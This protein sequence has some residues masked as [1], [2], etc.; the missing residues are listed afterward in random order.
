MSY[1]TPVTDRTLLDVVNQTSKG[2]FNAAD[3]ARVYNNAQLVNY[4]VVLYSGE[5]IVFHELTAP[6]R[7]TIP[8]GTADFNLFLTNIENIRAEMVASI[9]T[10]IAIKTDWESGINVPSPKYTHANQWESTLDAVWEFLDGNAIP[11]CTSLVS[12]RTILAGN[13]DLYIDCL[14]LQN[15]NL[16]IQGTGQLIIL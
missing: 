2:F 11:V 4:L 10:L 1:I 3:W 6:T 13:Y 5:D 14:D 9:P 12:D 7:S 15:F 8:R 16:E